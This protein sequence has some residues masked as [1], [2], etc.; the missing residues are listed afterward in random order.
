MTKPFIQYL[1]ESKQQYNYRIKTVV[2]LDDSKMESIERILRRYDSINIGTPQKVSHPSDSFEFRDI[3]AAEEYFIDVS[4]GMPLSSYILQ[5]EL[6]AVLNIPEKF[7]VV[8]ADNEPI[9][10]EAEKQQ[11][12]RDL[13]ALAKEKGL[14]PGSL[15]STDRF[16]LD[17]EQPKV[18]NAFGNEY[19]KTFL[20]FLADVAATR[21]P[22]E[23]ESQSTLISNDDLKKVTREP[24]Q[25]LA[26]FNADYDTPKPVSKPKGKAKYP[27]D[28]NFL[29]SAGNFDDDSKTYFKVNRTKKGKLVTNQMS[30]DKI[31]PQRSQVR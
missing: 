16:Y 30:T 27:V 12:L 4:I 7:I 15:L 17:V 11:M 21:K 8:R 2:Q 29:T 14:K 20:N 19:N 9:E 10:V 22:Q 18:K 1:E 13:N 3:D 31:R 26:D 28:P 24:T 5:Q 23:Y 6:R 25:D